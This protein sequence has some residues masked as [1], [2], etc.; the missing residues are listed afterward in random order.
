MGFPHILIVLSF[1]SIIQVSDHSKTEPETPPLLS[2]SCNGVF[3]SYTPTLGRKLKPTTEN[4]EEQAYKFKSRAKIVNNGLDELK[5]WKMYIGFQ[6]G[7]F[8]VSASNAILA[9]GTP[10]PKNTSSEDSGPVVFAGFPNANLKTEIET[11]GDLQQTEA[12]INIVG[13][14]FGVQPPVVPM[15]TSIGL[16]NDG[17]IC[18]FPKMQAFYNQSAIPCKTCACGCPASNN[19]CNTTA[20]AR[21]LPLD[22]LLVPFDNPTLMGKDWAEIKHLPISEP[23]PC[24]DNCGVSINW[25]IN[26]DNAQGWSARMT[27]FNWGKTN[28]A[29][30]FAAVQFRK[31]VPE[32]QEMHSFN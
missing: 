9:D 11:A 29:D 32:I 6:S 18:A 23:A 7:E 3:L 25:H 31:A 16:S 8:L 28:F 24:P 27:V 20:P 2:D 26:S 13:T 21:L 30:W 10:L 19:P 14:V 12:E 4:L 5:S 1:L 22:A 15:P 17:F